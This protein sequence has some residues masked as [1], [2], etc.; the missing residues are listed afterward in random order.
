MRKHV[1]TTRPTY[2]AAV[3]QDASKSYVAFFVIM[4]YS[5]R[6]GHR[7]LKPMP[8]VARLCLC[9]AAYYCFATCIIRQRLLQQNSD[10]FPTTF[11]ESNQVQYIFSTCLWIHYI[12]ELY[13]VNIHIV[14]KKPEKDFDFT[15]FTGI[16]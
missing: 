10:N 12:V 1:S 7:G 3:L 13:R 9:L 5:V 2:L 6:C 15:V 4:H 16:T 14:D 8:I 11:I